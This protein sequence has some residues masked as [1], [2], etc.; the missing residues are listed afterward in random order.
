LYEKDRVSEIPPFVYATDVS[1]NGTF[2]KKKNTECVSSQSGEGIL[3]GRGNGSFLLDDGD[4]LRISDTI[5]LEYHELEEA[6]HH[7]LT[8]TQEREKQLFASR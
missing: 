6:A 4:E 7:K 8:F 5:T 2:I 1:T 3:M